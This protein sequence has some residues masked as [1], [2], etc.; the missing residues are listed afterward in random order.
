MKKGALGC[1]VLTP[2]YCTSAS[3]S[4][5]EPLIWAL[6]FSKQASLIITYFD[7]FER[8]GQITQK[9][10]PQ[11]SIFFYKIQESVNPT[12][13]VNPKQKGLYNK[14]TDFC[15]IFISILF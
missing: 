7:V 4:E 13:E 15:F 3:T 5:D 10:F 6:G 14:M 8:C 9:Y 11:L 1:V 2:Q 12:D